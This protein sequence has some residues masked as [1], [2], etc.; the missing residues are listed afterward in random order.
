MNADV[1]P[2]LLQAQDQ[3]EG[4]GNMFTILMLVVLGLMIFMMFRS[5]KKNQKAQAERRNSLAPG[6]EVMTGSGIFGRVAS[7][8]LDGNKV[9]VE[10]SP[11]TVMTF[12]VQAI[13]NIVEPVVADEPVGDSE[14]QEDQVQQND[15]VIEIDDP[16]EDPKDR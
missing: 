2:A 7:V 6:V 11:G 16:R 12:H 4:G 9:D 14:T 13:A 3:A 1:T 8:D 10:V 5:S 15:P